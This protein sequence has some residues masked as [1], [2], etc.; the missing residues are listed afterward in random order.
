VSSSDDGVQDVSLANL[1]YVGSISKAVLRFWCHQDCHGLPREFVQKRLFIAL[2]KV[3]CE[4]AWA[5]GCDC[6]RAAFCE[7]G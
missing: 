5:G 2:N 3:V 6:V 1:A 7:F 4:P